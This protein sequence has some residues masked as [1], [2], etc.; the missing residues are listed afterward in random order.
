MFDLSPG[1]L[2]NVNSLRVHMMRCHEMP[3]S[4]FPKEWFE[5]KYKFTDLDLWELE[6]Y[7]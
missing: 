2:V 3:V 4:L 5:L 7:R 6:I 1:V